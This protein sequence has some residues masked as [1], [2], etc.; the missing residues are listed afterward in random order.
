MAEAGIATE[1]QGLTKRYG[2][3]YALQNLTESVKKGEFICILGPNGA[4]KTTLLKI[5]STLAKPTSGRAIIF[6]NDVV[7]EPEKVRASLRYLSHQP[8]LY[9]EFTP[10]ENLWFYGGLYGVKA[11]KK[12]YKQALE[13]FGLSAR[14]QDRVRGFSRGMKQRLALARVFLDPPPLLL[15]D[16][17]YTGLDSEG[18]QILQ[19]MLE[20]YH[21][22]EGTVLMSTHHPEGEI[23]PFSRVW[24]LEKGCLTGAPNS[25]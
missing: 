14:S 8:G 25:L 13:N 16:E 18:A 3:L 2:V 10:L 24:R 9:E 6:G 4:G 7:E 19:K 22:S 23:P 20:T 21:Q 17:P 11:G 5:L 12:E 1:I 15:L